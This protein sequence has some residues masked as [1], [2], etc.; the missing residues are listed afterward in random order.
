MTM[1]GNRLPLE[2]LERILLFSQ[3]PHA[4]VSACLACK[5]WSRI[6]EDQHFWKVKINILKK[7]NIFYSLKYKYFVPFDHSLILS[8]NFLTSFYINI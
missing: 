8:S 6:L 4:V 1:E 7:I 3:S 2:I 5:D